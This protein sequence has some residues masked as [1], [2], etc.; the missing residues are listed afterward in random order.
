MSCQPADGLF[1][2]RLF[3]SSQLAQ[4]YAV[5]KEIVVSVMVR[6]CG[7]GGVSASR[8]AAHQESAQ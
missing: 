8:K 7:R 1:Y 3:R 5:A 2:F 4:A 6:E